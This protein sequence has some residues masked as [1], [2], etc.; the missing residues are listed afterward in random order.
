[1]GNL[2]F[3]YVRQDILFRSGAVTLIHGGAG[4]ISREMEL[5]VRAQQDAQATLES[6]RDLSTQRNSVLETPYGNAYDVFGDA[7]L[8][9]AEAIAHQGIWRLEASPAF[10]AGFGSALQADGRCRLTAAV[11]ESTRRRLSA[12]INVQGVC[13]PSALAAALQYRQHGVRDA[14]GSVHLARE[15]RIPLENPE[16]PLQKERWR[17]WDQ[18]RHDPRAPAFQERSGTAGVV[19]CD[20]EGALCAITSTGGVGY[21]APGRVGDV[22]TVAGT[23]CTHRTAVSCTGFGEQI[24]SAALAARLSVRLEDGQAPEDCLMR[25]LEEGESAGFQFAFICLH[26]T[27]DGVLW[28]KGSTTRHCVWG[29]W[30]GLECRVN[31]E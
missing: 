17:K 13:H 2:R 7:H 11:M 23:Y 8:T 28:A 1:M 31:Q 16:T 10:N 20:A 21:E 4:P 6:L 27:P 15:L 9:L 18:E 25:T 5:S 12:V 19:S 3:G 26:K 14:E 29:L 24:M 30:S 22:P